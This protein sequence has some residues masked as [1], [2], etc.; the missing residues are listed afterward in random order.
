MTGQPIGFV[1]LGNMGSAL[2][3]NLVA[4]GH[5]VVVHDVAGGD[6]APH[7][8]RFVASTAEVA[9]EADIVVLSLPDG[10]ASELVARV[11]VDVDSRRTTTVVD[12]S[13]IGVQAAEA[14]AAA[15]AD[16]GISYVDAPVSGGPAG[17][18]ARTLT[19][20]YAGTDAA[21]G[22]AGPALEGLSDRRVRV[23]DRPGLGQ[24]MK[25]ANNFLS[26]CALAATSEAIAFGTRAGLS[27]DTMLEVLNSASGQSNATSEKFP[28]E[29]L[30]E[31]YAAG[32]TNHLMAKDVDLYLA[33]VTSRG[34]PHEIATPV[35]AVWQQF[36]A[37]QA[38]A[39]F[40]SIYRF[41]RDR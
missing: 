30:T 40:T 24:A 7:G 36:A 12:T 28:N 19:V 2:A 25:L 10:H 16:A 38:G 4:A 1:G 37:E 3:A 32:F 17:A 39:D 34:G 35:A 6:R 5:E 18:R 9:H 21:C 15:L 31:R 13:T 20:M 11:I 22:L 41:V 26:A 29:V 23:G 8:S 27:M 33:A 14:N